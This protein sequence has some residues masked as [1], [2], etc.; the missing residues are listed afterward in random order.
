MSVLLPDIYQKSIY[1]IDY[2][3]L[4]YAGIKVL[5]FDLDNTLAPI[6]VNEPSKKLKGLFDDL[7]MQ[8]FIPVIVSNSSQER[9]TPFKD[10]LMVDAACRAYKPLKRKFKKVL[11]VYHVKPFQV[12]VIG[13]QI[14]TD[15]WGSN[16][17]GFTSILI[18]PI[19]A[20]DYT[21][22]KFNRM[23]ENMILGHYTKLGVFKKG[24]YYE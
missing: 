15:V 14:L 2:K 12:A 24:E 11:T 22:T 13:D 6:T 3:S 9:V 23:I 19:G 10:G 4:K 17:M 5:L 20:N 7:R 16:R 1:T 8:G 21:S 18:N